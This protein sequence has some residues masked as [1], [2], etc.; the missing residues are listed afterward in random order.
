M[1]LSQMKTKE[2]ARML[3]TL[4]APVERIAHDEAIVEMLKS[5]EQKP[6]LEVLA[7]MFSTIVMALLDR[8]YDDVMKIISAMTGKSIESLEEQPIMETLNDAKGI[9]DDDLIRFFSSSARTGAAK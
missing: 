7:D 2:A 3:C 5:K 1:K 8:H 4:T 9:M 6:F